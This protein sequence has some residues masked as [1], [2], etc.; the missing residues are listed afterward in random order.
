MPGIQQVRLL[1]KELGPALELG[2]IVE[3]PDANA[4]GLA[5]RDGKVFFLEFVPDDDRLWL[6]ADAGTPRSEA[7]AELY[8]LMLQYNAQWQR[9]GGVRLAL[10]GPEGEVVIAYDL[11]ASGLDLPKLC[12]VIR[13]FQDMADGWRKIVAGTGR[14]ETADPAPAPA[15]AGIIRG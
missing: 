10:D 13:N 14:P 4:W 1:L 3:R 2:E 12:T 11:P 5:T 15:S 9:T 7:R 6:S 8:A